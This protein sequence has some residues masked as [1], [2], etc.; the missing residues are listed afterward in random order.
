MQSI[1]PSELTTRLHLLCTNVVPRTCCAKT[2]TSRS[3]GRG[4]AEIYPSSID[5]I[6]RTRVYAQ[7]VQH[8]DVPE[9]L[10]RV[11]D[12]RLKVLGADARPPPPRV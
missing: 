1:S 2:K 12:W 4:N 5:S 9:L 11:V 3:R 7:Q 8:P 6:P 10:D